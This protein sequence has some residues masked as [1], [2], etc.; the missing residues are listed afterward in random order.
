MTDVFIFA[1]AELVGHRFGPDAKWP[2]VNAIEISAATFIVPHRNTFR[3]STH[4]YL[5]SNCQHRSMW[6]CVCGVDS[7]EWSQGSQQYSH[8]T[9]IINQRHRLTHEVPRTQHQITFIYDNNRWQMKVVSAPVIPATNSADGESELCRS[10]SLDSFSFC[11]RTKA[12]TPPPLV[13]VLPSE[14]QSYYFMPCYVRSEYCSFICREWS[15]I[16]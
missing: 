11:M 14:M 16:S 6:L 1:V 2:E 3:V 13:F 10:S 4:L 5:N 9:Y 7:P 15:Q 8:I 12:H